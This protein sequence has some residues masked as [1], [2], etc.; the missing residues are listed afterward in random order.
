MAIVGYSQASA[1]KSSNFSLKTLA[2]SL[3]L[4]TKMR[5]PNKGFCSNQVKVS[6]KVTTS[7]TIIIAGEVNF[8]LATSSTIF[9]NVPV[10]TCCSG[11]V[12]QRMRA[13]GV[14]GDLPLL[15]NCETILLKFPT[16]I[17]KIKVPGSV[18]KRAQ[19]ILLSSLVG[20]SCPVITVK[21]EVKS[22]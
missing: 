9:S 20:S 4:V 21:V 17:K 5:L 1:P 3:A 14:F 7:P 18:A 13:I 22:R 11:R 8:A 16:P 6:L 19:L 10:T 15:T 2:C 12:P